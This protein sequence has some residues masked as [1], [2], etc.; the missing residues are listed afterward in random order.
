[1]HD[2]VRRWVAWDLSKVYD[3]KGNL[4]EIFCVGIDRTERKWQEKV[5]SRLSL[6]LSR[7]VRQRTADLEAMKSRIQH[8][9]NTTPAIIFTATVTAPYNIMFVSDYIQHLGYEPE[10]VLG[11]PLFDLSRVHPDDHSQVSLASLQIVQALENSVQD[12]PITVQCRIAKKDGT[13]CWIQKIVRIE[14]DEEGRALEIVA[15]WID[16]TLQKELEQKLEILSGPSPKLKVW[17]RSSNTL[18]ELAPI[19]LPLSWNDLHECLQAALSG[20]TVTGV[21]LQLQGKNGE[22]LLGKLTAGPVK[23]TEETADQAVGLVIEMRPDK[24]RLH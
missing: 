9:L 15:C 16:L 20:G 13:Y 21:S 2:G 6:E 1:M 12:Q 4:A 10:E 3:A 8:I 7:R 14:K 11:K 19:L 18:Q 24:S 17:K 22:S 5:L 23:S